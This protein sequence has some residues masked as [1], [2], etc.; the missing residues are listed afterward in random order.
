MS[1][2]ILLEVENGKIPLN[3]ENIGIKM[4][5]GY[6]KIGIAKI[7]KTKEKKRCC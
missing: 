2:R 7:K 1:A 6:E 4:G 5:D 3:L